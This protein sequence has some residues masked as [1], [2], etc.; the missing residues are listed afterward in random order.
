MLRASRVLSAVAVCAFLAVFAV[1]ANANAV[2]TAPLSVRIDDHD[3][4]F[5][6]PYFHGGATAPVTWGAAYNYNGMAPDTLTVLPPDVADP[7]HYV[8][9][10][11]YTGKLPTVPPLPTIPPSPPPP[12]HPFIYPVANSATFGGDLKLHMTFDINFGPYI[13]ATNGDRF[14]ISLGGHHPESDFLTITGQIFNQAMGPGSA[15]L[16]PSDATPHDIVLLNIQLTDV[17]ILARTGEDR[18]FLV[19]GKGKILTGLGWDMSQVFEDPVGV[20]FY[21]FFA[22]N[23]QAPIFTSDTYQ[24]SDDVS[25]KIL[26]HISGEAGGVPEP[27]TL[28]LLAL[29]GVGLLARHRRK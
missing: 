18:L 8:G 5:D 12:P 27:A 20:T 29:G 4:T 17:T 23:P 11:S 25:G 10:Y 15:A 24:P 19:E 9:S 7:N 1:T 16:Y 2:P 6:V 28:A 13:D 14:D 26:G 22:E 3:F 21:K